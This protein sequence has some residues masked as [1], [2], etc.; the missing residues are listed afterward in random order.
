MVLNTGVDGLAQD[1][2][3]NENQNHADEQPGLLSSAT[4]T[5]IT[6]D[7]D[8]ETSYKSQLLFGAGAMEYTRDR[9][10]SEGKGVVDLPSSKTGQANTKPCAQLDEAS[11]QRQLL[12]EITRDQD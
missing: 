8:C 4:D 10:L 5:S 12:L 3:E 6:D 9:S 1:F 11:I 7:T 2:S